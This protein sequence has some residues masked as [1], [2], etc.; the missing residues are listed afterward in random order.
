MNA[1][2]LALIGTGGHG[3]THVEKGLRLHAEGR[4]R[5]VAVADP[6]PPAADERIPLTVQ[7]SLPQ[8]ATAPTSG[9]TLSQALTFT[10]SA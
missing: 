2:R 1:P 3:R 5:L 4:V 9:V 10:F 7:V 6:N 8:N